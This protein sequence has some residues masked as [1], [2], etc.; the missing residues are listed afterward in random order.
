M[1]YETNLAPL[2]WN[3][4]LSLVLMSLTTLFISFWAVYELRG[5]GTNHNHDSYGSTEVSS[6]V[7]TS[8]SASLH[9]G[10][11][12]IHIAHSSRPGRT[13]DL[14]TIFQSRPKMETVV[15]EIELQ[16]RPNSIYTPFVPKSV[17]SISAP[18][19]TSPQPEDRGISTR[20]SALASGSRKKGVPGLPH[21]RF[22]PIKPGVRV[23]YSGPSGKTQ[24][25]K[26]F[27]EERDTT[28]LSG[29]NEHENDE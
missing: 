26:G 27:D 5:G 22:N 17:K 6:S 16:A 2:N 29:L 23:R 12:G 8:V 19:F 28:L 3:T 21:P 25:Q 15:D 1:V 4:V 11:S 13:F 14:Q 7:R 18:L 24:G 9:E 20:T 10:A